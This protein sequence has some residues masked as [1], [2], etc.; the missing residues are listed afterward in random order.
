MPYSACYLFVGMCVS[1]RSCVLI[2][3]ARSY[4]CD[5][6]WVSVCVCV[7]WLK[8]YDTAV[9]SVESCCMDSLSEKPYILTIKK[10]VA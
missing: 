2:Y 7:T 3:A 8:H 6:G 4:V 9:Q 10:K 5:C 1:L